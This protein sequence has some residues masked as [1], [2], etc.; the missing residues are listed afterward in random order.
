MADWT[1]EGSKSFIRLSSLIGLCL[2][3]FVGC[4]NPS[5]SDNP[6][7]KSDAPATAPQASPTPVSPSNQPVQIPPSTGPFAQQEQAGRSV[8]Y[9][10]PREKPTE[11]APMSGEIINAFIPAI[12]DL[13]KHRATLEQSERE[14]LHN[15]LEQFKSKVREWTARQRPKE[16][17][18]APLPE[19][20]MQPFAFNRP[21][22]SPWN[23]LTSG[24]DALIPSAHAQ[25]IDAG[26]I[27]AV[28]NGMTVTQ[29]LGNICDQ[30]KVPAG[31]DLSGMTSEYKDQNGK[32]KFE[33]IREPDGTP[34]VAFESTMA[35]PLFF[36]E[37]NS[38]IALTGTALCPDPSGKVQFKIKLGQAGRAG[39]GNSMI[40]DKSREATIT[41]YVDDNADI[42]SADIKTQHSERST[43]GGRQVYIESATDWHLNGE[44]WKSLQLTDHRIV[45][46]SSQASDADQS[47]VLD[48][49]K[50][51]IGLAMGAL[52]GAKI[53]WEDGACI[54][55]NATSPGTVKPKA[56]SNIPVSVTH[57]KEETAVPAKV[58]V[59]LEGGQSVA[60][61]LIPHAP[62]DVTHV[63]VDK[64]GVTMTITLKA[65]SKRGG[66]REWLKINTKGMVFK[67]DGGADEFH[68]TGIVCDF[69]K[70]FKVKGDGLTL[71]FTPSSKTSGTYKYSGKLHGFEA[72]G[73]GTYTVQYNG[74]DPVHVTA[75]GPGTVKTP[76]GDMTAEGTE[77]YSVSASQAGCPYDKLLLD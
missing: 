45:R 65:R 54:K 5:S 17:A 46:A 10:L 12:P 29:F 11:F 37:A 55:I 9:A 51:S 52:M 72:W 44:D 50:H 21:A 75:K 22:P 43:A 42:A 63:A 35:V 24:L 8:A 4:N 62:G 47:L 38:R 58:T 69:E 74:D 26:S 20:P 14:L 61:T 73:K 49:I 34:T 28:V 18:A 77:E 13:A 27:I 1:S 3:T 39:S 6:A 31:T 33:V 36:L 16:K 15:A 41:A 57:R 66:A 64:E 19:A 60:P 71:T 2:L 68:G 48:G 32:A 30:G 67:L 40:Y 56:T 76:M 59:E 7:K 23:W 53:R 70:P 25:G